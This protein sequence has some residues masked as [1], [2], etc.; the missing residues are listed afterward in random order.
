MAQVVW[1]GVQHSPLGGGKAPTAQESQSE[2]EP[3]ASPEAE[4]TLEDTPEVTP[5]ATPLVEIEK[6]E[7]G[8]ED[9][10]YTV[11]MAA[12]KSTRD[13]WPTPAPETSQ[14]APD[15]PSSH[16]DEHTPAQD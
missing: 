2:A 8:T 9:T 11:D 3:E 10:D 12:T 5:A 6:D 15:A 14:P 16:H 4:G 1:P 13:P 7:D